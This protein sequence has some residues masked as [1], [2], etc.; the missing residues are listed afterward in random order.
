M[1]EGRDLTIVHVAPGRYQPFERS[2]VS[3]GIWRELASGFGP[4]HVL[5]RSSG[6]PAEWSDS[7]LHITLIKSRFGREAEFLFSQFGQVGRMLRMKPDVVVCQSPAL[8]GLAALDVARQSGARTLMELHGM[9]FFA[10]ARFGSQLWLLQKISSFAL[11]RADRIR[12]LSPGMKRALGNSYGADLLGRTAIL[13]PRVDTTRFVAPAKAQPR[14]GPLRVAMVGT[15]NDNKG[16]LRLVKALA[17]TTFPIELHIVGA[18]P[19]LDEVRRDVARIADSGS[20][21]SV[22]FH[23]RVSHEDVAAILS[24]CDVFVFYSRMESAGRAMMEAMAAGLPAVLTNA[25]FCVEFVEDGIEGFVLG[26]D[27]DREILDV[28]HRFNDEPGLASRMGA[29][30]HARAVRDYD[31]VRLFE[32]Y[33]RLIVETAKS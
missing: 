14:S 4:Y 24:N 29:A 19:Q 11:K 1:T 22:V 2:H 8:G 33:R 12:V 9:E 31:S 32:D 16:Q 23:G 25:G 6:E 15:V 27:P 20:M 18:G 30:A 3:Y 21:L 7:N 13:P 26:A 17:A 5:A 28:L 10:P